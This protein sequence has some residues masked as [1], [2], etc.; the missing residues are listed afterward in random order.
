MSKPLIRPTDT[1]DRS[2]TA[3][4]YLDPDN[5]PLTTEDLR[6]FKR[7]KGRPAGSQKKQVS[8]RLDV[9]ILEAFKAQGQGWQ[10]RINAVLRDWV[11]HH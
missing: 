9:D 5:P 11:R 2:I 3:N 4:A 7:G 8:L 10:T 6:Q 1:E